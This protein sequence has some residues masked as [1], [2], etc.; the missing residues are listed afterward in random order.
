MNLHAVL[1]RKTLR[2]TG[3]LLSFLVV[4]AGCFDPH[5]LGGTGDHSGAIIE[6]EQQSGHYDPATETCTR[7][8]GPE[9]RVY[10]CADDCDCTRE[11]LSSATDAHR[12]RST[13]DGGLRCS[14]VS[15]AAPMAWC[16]GDAAAVSN[17]ASNANAVDGDAGSGPADA[18]GGG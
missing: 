14:F 11:K 15:D 16:S 7:T 6:C 4:P 17:D 3:L 1:W 5:A 18:G 13:R 9:A 12:C 8:G 10:A 2:S